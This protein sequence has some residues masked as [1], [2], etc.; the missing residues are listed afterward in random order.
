[1]AD[2]N[3][4]TWTTWV[5]EDTLRA[6]LKIIST[7]PDKVWNDLQY[8]R[9]A[10]QEIISDAFSTFS[11]TSASYQE[12]A[13]YPLEPKYLGTSE[14]TDISWT[15]RAWCDASTTATVRLVT[16]TTTST[17]TVSDTTAT[18]QALDTGHTEDADN[19]EIGFTLS[20][21]RA[22]GAGTCY[23]SG[24]FAFCEAD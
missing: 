2:R 4:S 14:T 15:V 3:P 24:V 22:T 17:I 8:F 1:M 7:E 21:L 19:T 12:F 5:D 9:D 23:V 16:P 6:G 18:W 13:R 10:P 20:I 11:T